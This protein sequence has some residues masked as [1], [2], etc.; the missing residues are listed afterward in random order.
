MRPPL[1]AQVSWISMAADVVEK[2][3]CESRIGQEMTFLVRMRSI[4]GQPQPCML[5]MDYK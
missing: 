2:V 3:C 1:D 4:R 5:G